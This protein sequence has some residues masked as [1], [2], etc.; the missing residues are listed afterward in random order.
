MITIHLYLMDA[1]ETPIESF[2]DLPFNP[3]VEGDEVNVTIDEIFPKTLSR[4]PKE[5]Q[6]HFLE[7]NRKHA[8][9]FDRK[10]VRL[11]QEQKFINTDTFNH[12]RIIIEYHCAI[13]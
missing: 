4:F 12:N 11:K 10:R 5:K 13:V 2:H 9:L 7:E 8:E 1:D 3:F 6:G